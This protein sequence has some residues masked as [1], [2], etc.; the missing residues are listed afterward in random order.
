MVLNYS[1]SWLGKLT[2]QREINEGAGEKMPNDV[3]AKCPSVTDFTEDLA[4]D[5]TP[6]VPVAAGC[7]PFVKE[8][9]NV[10]AL[11]GVTLVMLV[12]PD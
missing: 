2:L 10:L 4:W 12:G 11:T 3:L 6:Y 1:L 8:R 7:K 5:P 9:V